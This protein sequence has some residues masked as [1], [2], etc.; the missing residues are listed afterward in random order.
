MTEPSKGG[1]IHGLTRWANWD[2]VKHTE[3]KAS[4]RYVLHACSGW[5]GVLDCRLDYTLKNSGLTVRTTA[6]NF[7]SAPCPY[8][9]GAHPYL[10]AGTATINGARTRS[11]VCVPASR[12]PR[13]SYLRGTRERHPL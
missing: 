7:G 5:N 3:I 11:R 2:L 8:G 9:T 12:R 1:A 10:S 13:D 6:I 4:F